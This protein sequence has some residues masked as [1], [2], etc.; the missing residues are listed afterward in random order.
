MDIYCTYLTVYLGNKMP[1]FYIGHSTVSKV[2]N[3]YRGSVC[4]EK[5]RK[6]WREE[7]SYNPH[8]FKT[9]ILT[10]H[11]TRDDAIIKEECF[12]EK[13]NVVR[14][15]LYINCAIARRTFRLQDKRSPETILKIKNG[16]KKY[17]KTND[18]KH[19][20]SI[21]QKGRP[22]SPETIAKMREGQKKRREKEANL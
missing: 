16:L 18:H 12:Q 21:N 2:L 19:K 22:K 20:L 17:A 9:I 15:P 4:S 3:G 6:T 7:L 8:L 11:S 5:Y 10:Q 1:P 13:M 14:N